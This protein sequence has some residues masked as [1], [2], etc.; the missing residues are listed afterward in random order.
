MNPFI[1]GLEGI[2]VPFF[3]FTMIVLVVRLNNRQMQAK[4]QARAEL[5][6]HFLTVSP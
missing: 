1:L 4:A 2:L 6:K 3:V 5:N